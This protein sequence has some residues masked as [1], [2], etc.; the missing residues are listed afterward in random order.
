METSRRLW[1]HF[2]FVCV[3]A[4]PSPTFGLESV[5]KM[6]RLN[7][8]IVSW[9]TKTKQKEVDEVKHWGKAVVKQYDTVLLPFSFFLKYESS[10]LAQV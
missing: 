1:L 8:H 6:K 7:L 2:A 5:L 3:E 10:F 9:G 4:K